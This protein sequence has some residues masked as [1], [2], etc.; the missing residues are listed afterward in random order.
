M[1]LFLKD[2]V[3]GEKLILQGKCQQKSL[4]E[5]KNQKAHNIEEKSKI[6]DEAGENT[7]LLKKR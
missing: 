1:G 5:H 6:M 7:G 3:A 2:V 4:V